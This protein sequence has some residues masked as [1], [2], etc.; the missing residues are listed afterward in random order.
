MAE[1]HEFKDELAGTTAVICLMK[2]EKIF[3]VRVF[4]SFFVSFCSLACHNYCLESNQIV[5][6]TCC[7]RKKF[8]FQGNVGDSRAVV[9]VGGLA[10]P[11]SYDHKPANEPE[12]R[13]IVAAGGW[14]E[15]N[16]VNGNLALSRALGTFRKFPMRKL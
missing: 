4:E 12:A 10:E 5:K 7:V 13:R 6:V 1:D 14:V 11:L 15:F 2:E 9:S 8:V 3:C 16:R